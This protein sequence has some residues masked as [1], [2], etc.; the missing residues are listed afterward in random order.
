MYELFE[1]VLPFIQGGLEAAGQEA[2]ENAI[3]PAQGEPAAPPSIPRVAADEAGPSH[4]VKNTSLESSMRNRIVRLE[5]DN[6]PYLLDK[7][8]GDYWAQIRHE[9]DHASGV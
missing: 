7:A 6:S 4:P 8:K 2:G 9:L 3:P 1:V 5:Q